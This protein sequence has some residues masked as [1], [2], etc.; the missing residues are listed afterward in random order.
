M[1][2]VDVAIVSVRRRNNNGGLHLKERVFLLKLQSTNQ[3]IQP[4]SATERFPGRK[5]R[6]LPCQPD[7]E[8]AR[9]IGSEARLHRTVHCR[10]LQKKALNQGQEM[11]LNNLRQKYWILRFRWVKEY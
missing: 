1:D 3:Q 5:G 10:A 4:P 9:I 11:V 8:P 2:S 7:W 6:S